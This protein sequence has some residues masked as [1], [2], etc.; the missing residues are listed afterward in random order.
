MA[1]AMTAKAATESWIAVSAS[2]RQKDMGEEC[3]CARAEDDSW[4]GGL[5][6]S[7]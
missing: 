3:G 1:E 5:G 6:V 4:E 7:R 2:R